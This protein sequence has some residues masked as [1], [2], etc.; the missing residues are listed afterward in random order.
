MGKG[1]TIQSWSDTT[2][3]DLVGVFN[4]IQASLS[5]VNDGASII[6]TGSLAAQLGSATNRRGGLRSG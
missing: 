6:A 4:V 5:Y 1:Q 2:D 3:T